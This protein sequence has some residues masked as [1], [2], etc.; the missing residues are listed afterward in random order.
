M[1]DRCFVAYT[2]LKKDLP[3]WQELWGESIAE[4][5]RPPD[6]GELLFDSRR[7]ILR[8]EQEEMNYGGLELSREA[9]AAGL[10]FMMQNGP[11]CDYPAGTGVGIGSQFYDSDGSFESI[12]VWVHPGG[13]V[14][15]TEAATLYYERV[16]EVETRMRREVNQF[17]R[18]DDAKKPTKERKKHGRTTKP[19]KT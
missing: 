11:G 3:K 1:G 6:E 8:I 13:A 10:I 9:A 18:D 15:G 16:R 2:I 12:P 7:G 19:V 17:L 14:E 5:A 4:Y